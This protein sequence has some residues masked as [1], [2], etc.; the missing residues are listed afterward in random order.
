MP[1][2]WQQA[3]G[4]TPEDKAAQLSV[5]LV[6]EYLAAL[7]RQY[8]MSRTDAAAAAAAGDPDLPAAAAPPP[9]SPGVVPL[10][11]APQRQQQL[12]L[13]LA[14]AAGVAGALSPVSVA[15]EEERGAGVARLAGM[16]GEAVSLLVP[17]ATSHSSFM[18]RASAGS[19]VLA[20]AGLTVGRAGP[21]Y[22]HP[23]AAA[24]SLPKKSCCLP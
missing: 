14:G 16:W 3:G 9:P 13:Q 10:A 6:S 11:A 2:L 19:G 18:V 20:C 22:A 5:K 4:A 15:S 1:R 23:T 8:G 24:V 21:V 7:A 17:A 12:R